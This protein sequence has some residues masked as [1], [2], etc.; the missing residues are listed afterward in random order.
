MQSTD[1]QIR[2]LSERLTALENEKAA[3]KNEISRLRAGA[4]PDP[5]P[6]AFSAKEKINIFMSLFRGRE[7]IFPKRWDNPKTG[8]SGYAPACRNEWVRG[9]CEKPRIKCGACQHQAFISVDGAIMQK[10]LA[11]ENSGDVWKDHTIG[12]YPMLKDETCLFLA[13]DF[14]KEYWQRDAAAF[15][16]TCRRRKIPASLERSRSGNGAHV[17][18]FFSEPVAA[19][20]ARKMGAA[21]I[22]ETMERCPEIGFE[23]YDRF[24][25]S[26]DT[27]PSGGFG[28]LIAL[29][30]QKQPREKGNSL[31]LDENFKPYADQ[32]GYL[33]SIAKM[34]ASQVSSI[35]AEATAK[36]RIVGVRMPMDDE[37]D[38]P[39][40]MRPS[41]I[42][43]DIATDQKLP[44]ALELVLGNQLYIAKEHLPP[45][46][47]NALIRLAAFQNPEFYMA[48]AMRLSTFGKP[49]VITCAEEFPKYIGLP[50]GCADEAVALLK[51]LDVRV[52]LEDKRETGKPVYVSFQGELTP[53]QKKAAR[54]LLAHD[55]GVL[56]ATTAFGKTVVAAHMVAERKTNTLI[57]VHRKQLLE[58]WVARLQTF[59]DIPHKNIGTIYGGN[60]KP[61]GIVD[62][63]LIQ[64]L[65]R[66]GV[67]DDVVAGY[68]QLI[69]DECHHLSAVSFEAVARACKAK[70]V[71][72]L[73]ATVTRK[74][75]HHPIIFMQCGPIRYRV[76]PK[77][78]AALR[79]FT[80]KVI[81]RRTCSEM[82]AA[83]NSQEKPVIQQL[84]AAIAVDE[85]RNGMI[86]DDVLKSLESGRAPLVLTE[87]RDHATLLANKLSK[88]CR[89]IILMTG[90]QTE[91]HQK[92]VREKLKSIPD[93][94][95]RLLIATGRYIGE[96]FDDA[97]LDTLFLTMPVSWH[98]TLAQYAGR[99]HRLHHAKKEVLIYDYVDDHIPVFARMAEKRMKGY[100]R[101]GYFIQPEGPDL[102]L[103]QCG[104]AS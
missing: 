83:A 52:D 59:L 40:E 77:T 99:L 53:E 68:G 62:V 34:S 82:T 101:I 18:I 57:L 14:D 24:F 27:M 81:T 94:D 23:S 29:P 46:L 61:T 65:V 37:E 79:P 89:H 8:K 39:W 42:K 26:Q 71:L 17:W 1:E 55:T 3:L 21:L 38:Q 97:R 50:R 25:P 85:K 98:G 20:E 91:K 90:G 35:A 78:Q 84:Y 45:A 58:Q 15:L 44:E 96:G 30:L 93:N 12:I 11:G 48:Q 102:L 74:D 7:D 19:S 6:S 104:V 32:W 33:A 63:A 86:F 76:D 16:A 10:H 87:R 95:E 51:S 64:S 103:H 92:E 67:V 5:A 69:V 73:S 22:T 72:G 66:K 9:V 56:A 4:I 31:F 41:S 43:S 80:H 13:A 60:R 49:R 70:Y 54:A 2:I 100:H 28:N 36:G 75:G 47:K 88:F